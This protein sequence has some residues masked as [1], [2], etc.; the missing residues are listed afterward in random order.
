MLGVLT[1]ILAQFVMIAVSTIT[2]LEM[3]NHGHGTG[4]VGLVIAVHVACMYLPSPVTGWLVDRF[5]SAKIALTSGFMFLAAGIAAAIASPQSVAL[6]TFALALLGFAWNLGL[7]SGT[8][9]VT[10]NVPLETRAKTQGMVDLSIAIAGATGGLSA[11]VVVGLAGFPLL[12]L[13]GGVVALAIL[14]V[15]VITAR[16][17]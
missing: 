9:L 16:V 11:G 1:M 3:H 14:P 17:R 6:L 5:G 7:I 4:A 10:E 8:A 13:G 15:V 2:P 12:A